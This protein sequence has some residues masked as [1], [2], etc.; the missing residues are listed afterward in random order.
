MPTLS[1]Q[2]ENREQAFDLTE[3]LV[4]RRNLTDSIASLNAGYLERDKVIQQ[5]NEQVDK[6]D[7]LI[8]YINPQKEGC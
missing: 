4:A 6:I 3:L 1:S 8:K 2:P 5:V 7:T